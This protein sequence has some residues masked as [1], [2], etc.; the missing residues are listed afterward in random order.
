VSNHF[1]VAER[2][3]FLINNEHVVKMITENKKIIFEILLKSLLKNSKKHWNQSV[4]T[5][6][7]NVMKSLMEIDRTLFE[8]VSS[9][10]QKEEDVLKKQKA[11]KSQWT[12]LEKEFS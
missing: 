3:L 4:Q 5:M 11:I 2:I 8:D 6:T 12:Q 9:K 1:Q 10:I 7:L